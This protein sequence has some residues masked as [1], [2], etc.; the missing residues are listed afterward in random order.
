MMVMSQLF[1][2][3]AAVR[4][5]WQALGVRMIPIDTLVHNFLHRTGILSRLGAAHAYG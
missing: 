2:G 5:A 3:T 4:P 1:L